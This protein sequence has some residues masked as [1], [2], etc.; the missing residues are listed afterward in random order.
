M[1]EKIKKIIIILI[2]IIIIY[3]GLFLV[4]NYLEDHSECD[5]RCPNAYMPNDYCWG[6]CRE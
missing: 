2:G 5:C 4:M 1:K 6:Y 3:G